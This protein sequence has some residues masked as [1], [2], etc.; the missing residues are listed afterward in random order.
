MMSNE[1]REQIRERLAQIEASNG[2][3]L[4]ADLV[5]EDAKD[6][7]S[8]LHDQ[9]EWDIEKAALR[10]WIDQAREI[11]TSV[12]VVQR[13]DTQTIST[14]YYVRDPSAGPAEQGYVS[15][16]RLRTES[17]LAREAIHSEF[18]RA[19]AVLQRA[20]D[21]AKVLGMEEEVVEV[22]ERVDVLMNRVREER[23]SA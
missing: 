2:G 13:V 19:R 10:H 15:L 18:V 16:E 9:F 20:R 3:R 12:R 21:I 22:A 17:D 5:V 7:D 6:P 11:I 8:P 14:V 1:K 23:Q 4:T